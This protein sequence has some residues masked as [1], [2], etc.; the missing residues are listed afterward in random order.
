M[1]ATRRGESVAIPTCPLIIKAPAVPTYETPVIVYPTQAPKHMPTITVEAPQEGKYEVY[2][3]TGLL[4][5]SGR[6]EEGKTSVTLP[7]INGIY[8]IRTFQGRDAESHKV[9]LY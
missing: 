9:I 6:L 5:E 8:F 1:M 4:I 2:S 7:A 3:S